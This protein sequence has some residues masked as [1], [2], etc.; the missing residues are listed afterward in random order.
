MV[1]LVIA[2]LLYTAAILIGA[3]ASRNA[4]TN[5][6]SAVT[7][8]ISVVIPVIIIIPVM[9]KKT[10][11][12]QKYGILMAV[13]GGLVISL[14]VLALNKS[15]TQNKIGIVAPVVFGGAILLSTVLSSFIFKEKISS[16]EGAGLVLMLGGLM[17]LLYARANA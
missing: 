4:N 7:N 1:Y 6:V 11:V 14:F 10:F 15:F 2:L 8:L 3:I 9:S 13:L 12:S 5:I 17:V 16:I